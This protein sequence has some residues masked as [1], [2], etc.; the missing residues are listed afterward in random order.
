MPTSSPAVIYVDGDTPELRSIAARLGLVRLPPP[1][2]GAADAVV[3]RAEADGLNLTTV[4]AGSAAPI[5]ID[6]DE[7]AQRRRW[8]SRAQPLVR[9]LGRTCERVVDAT[10]GFGRD[11]F[12][13]AAAGHSVIALERHAVLHALLDDALARARASADATTADVAARIESRCLDAAEW[14]AAFDRG[15]TTDARPDVVYFDPMFA[16]DGRTA[17]PKKTMQLLRRLL[18]PD[19]VTATTVLVER[20]MRVARRRVVVKRHRDDPPLVPTSTPA[21]VGRRI[22]FDVYL[23]LAP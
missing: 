8:S 1:G 19:P 11:A 5:R 23:S 22:R 13:I 17:L 9:A 4:D 10:A 20:A 18:G 3:L 16:S 15:A 7:P 14:L 2:A 12:T 6:F 21:V